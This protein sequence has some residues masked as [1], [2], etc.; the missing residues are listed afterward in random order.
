MWHETRIISTSPTLRVWRACARTCQLRTS[1]DSSPSS[2]GGFAKVRTQ[3]RSLSAISDTRMGSASI[4]MAINLK[5]Q[6]PRRQA[7]SPTRQFVNYNSL[8]RVSFVSQIPQHKSKDNSLQCMFSLC[9]DNNKKI[10]MA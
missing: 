10:S 3:S 5:Q 7:D 8:L 4:S 2:R 1:V 6:Y 9:I